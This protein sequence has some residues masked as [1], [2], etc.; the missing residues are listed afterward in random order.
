METGASLFAIL[1]ARQ[2]IQHFSFLSFSE[3]KR[4]AASGR[5]SFA[6]GKLMRYAPLSLPRLRR[7][8]IKSYSSSVCMLVA[9]FLFLDFT[10]SFA[11][12]TSVRAAARRRDRA[13]FIFRIGLAG[14]IFPTWRLWSD[15]T[16]FWLTD[17]SRGSSKTALL[18]SLVAERSQFTS[19]KTRGPKQLVCFLGDSDTAL[20][21]E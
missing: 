9:A 5:I 10:P 8:M 14:F 12:H 21:T 2:R 15:R 17:P 6:P 1:S 3:F 13:S 16:R 4:L 20:P 11:A 18:L 19:D 7:H